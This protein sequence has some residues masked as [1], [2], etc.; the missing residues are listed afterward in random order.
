MNICI[1][2]SIFTLLHQKALYRE[3]DSLLVIADVHLGKASHFRKEGISIPA[4]AQH[5]DYERLNSL[6]S[7]VSP[8]KVIFLGDLFHSRING[9]WQNFATIIRQWP[10]IQFILVRGNHDLIN[11]SHFDEM[12]ILVTDTIEDDDCVYTHEPE[13]KLHHHKTNIAGHIHPG[14]LL[15]GNAKQSV[16]L[17]CFYATEKQLILPAFGA[18]TGL[19][20]MPI[21]KYATIY[22]VLPASVQQIG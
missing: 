5:A 12:N 18:L 22:G 7:S 8:R 1:G 10:D 9:D 16:R 20:M 13:T 6:F 14:V 2:K 11:E 17:P 15:T 19:Q 4:S 21:T 3:A